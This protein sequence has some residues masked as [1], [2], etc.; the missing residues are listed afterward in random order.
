V[1]Q[2]QTDRLIELGGVCIDCGPGQ[3]ENMVGFYV[4]ALGAEVIH[5]EQ[6]WASLCDPGGTFI[7]IQ[8]Q[9]W[10]E[11]P[12]WPEHLPGQTKMIHFECGV[13]DM[14]AAVAAVTN[15]WWDG[16]AVPALGPRPQQRR[17]RFPQTAN[18]HRVGDPLRQLR[19]GKRQQGAPEKDGGRG[20]SRKTS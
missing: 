8:A 6:R 17:V 14:E 2:E 4:A 20:G 11:P 1:T 3:F 16:G 9:N 7:N 18:R 12:V 15:F 13:S 19:E 10:Y 5:H